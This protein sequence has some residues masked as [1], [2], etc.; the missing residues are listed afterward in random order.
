MGFK[1]EFPSSKRRL[2]REIPMHLE[3]W[4][5]QFPSRFPS[6]WCW[7]QALAA[8]TTDGAPHSCLSVYF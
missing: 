4:V 6:S 7:D 8:E 3:G 5:A 1:K 2:Q